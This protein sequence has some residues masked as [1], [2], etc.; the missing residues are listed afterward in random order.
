ML[1]ATVNRVARNTAELINEG[2]RRQT[3][4]N[5]ARFAYAGPDDIDRRLVE[6]D[7]EWDIE[8]YLETMAPTFTLIGIALGLTTDRK[9]FALACLVQ[10]FFLQHALQGW[11]PP[12]PILRRLGI[13][14]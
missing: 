4:A 6:L 5:I 3:E 12:I 10:S 14:T 2:I 8:R 9:W 13:R 7:Y 1:P 11:C